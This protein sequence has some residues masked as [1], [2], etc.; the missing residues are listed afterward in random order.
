MKLETLAVHA[1]HRPDAATRAVAPPIHLSTTFERAP[2]GSL[3]HGWLY[4]RNANPTRDALE[5]CLAALEGGAEAAA[6]ASGSA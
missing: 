2:D 5:H 1:G 4:S 6:F 3:P